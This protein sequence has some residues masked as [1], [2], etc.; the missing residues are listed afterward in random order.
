[1]AAHTD[2]RPHIARGKRVLFSHAGK[3]IEDEGTEH[4][5][6]AEMEKE[7]VWNFAAG[8]APEPVEPTEEQRK[9]LLDSAS[10]NMGQNEDH[11]K[12]KLRT[13]RPSTKVT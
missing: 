13:V 9:R 2:G 11:S 12:S 5:F 7:V 8:P 4:V 10:V 6:T 1:M 3:T